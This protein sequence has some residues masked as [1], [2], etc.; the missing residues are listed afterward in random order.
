MPLGIRTQSS[1]SLG[2]LSPS[3]PTIILRVFCRYSEV[4]FPLASRDRA[5]AED[6]AAGFLSGTISQGLLTAR[7]I[8]EASP[9][10]LWPAPAERLMR[11]ML[12]ACRP[13]EA[14]L[15]YG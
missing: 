1:P 14:Q 3:T 12:S 13:I 6:L 4:L 5:S 15:A 10:T 9:P 7:V 8:V 11:K 2:R